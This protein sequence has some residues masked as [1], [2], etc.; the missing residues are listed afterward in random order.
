MGSRPA[1]PPSRPTAR[2][3]PSPASLPPSPG[4][5]PIHAFPPPI[6]VKVGGSLL[7]WPGLP[8]ALPALLGSLANPR[9]VLVVGGGSIV[10][11]LRR[12]DR[13]HRLGEERSHALALR[14]MDLT[15]QLL[16]ALVPGL[17]VVDE[18]DALGPSWGRG[19]I[20]VLAPRRTLDAEDRSSA[21]PLPHHWDV[22]SDSIA[23]RLAVR[24]GAPG[25]VLLKSAS[26]PPG[27]DR[28][29][30]AA[31]G[32]VDPGFPAVSRSIPRVTL[33]NLRDPDSPPAPLP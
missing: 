14:A 6:V 29:G 13:T 27:L 12:L 30:A 31:L 10:D 11:M 15:A 2:G 8:D 21:D 28:E 4:P 23:A 33:I 5:L 19:E 1:D 16:A 18:V 9:A 17:A 22:T 26:A 25:L 3:G 24:L 20:P 32:L 7:D